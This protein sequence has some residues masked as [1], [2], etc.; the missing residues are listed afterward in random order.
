[1]YILLHSYDLLYCTVVYNNVRFRAGL[2][3]TRD[4][5]PAACYDCCR[6]S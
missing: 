1:M 3:I 4:V 6:P 2:E 5:L